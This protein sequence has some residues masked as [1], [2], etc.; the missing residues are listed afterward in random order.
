MSVRAPAFFVCGICFAEIRPR[1]YMCI[2][3]LQLT[4]HLLRRL[5]RRCARMRF[6]GRDRLAQRSCRTLPVEA[7][8]RLT[9]LQMC[10]NIIL[11]RSGL[12]LSHTT[13]HSSCSRPRARRHRTLTTHPSYRSPL[14]PPLSPP[15]TPPAPPQQQPLG[16]RLGLRLL[17][18]RLLQHLLLLGAVKLD[19]ALVGGARE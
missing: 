12:T 2:L 17:H 13:H 16:L 18:D 15:I 3:V 7:D 14:Q 6:V 9:K 1:C 8:R 10:F 19:H 11:L 4:K 5:N